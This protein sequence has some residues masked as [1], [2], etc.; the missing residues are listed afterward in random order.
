MMVSIPLGIGL[1]FSSLAI[2]FRDV[3]QAMPFLI[4]MMMFSAPIVYSASSIPETYRIL[5]SLNPIVG[6]IEGFRACL[7][8]TPIP[9][10]YI[11]PGMITATI[12]LIGGAF[13]FKRMERIIVDVI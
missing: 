4:R 7:L 3:K 6:V 13:Y 8:G 5:Y 12:L 9:W 1:A 11:W 2:R 10:L